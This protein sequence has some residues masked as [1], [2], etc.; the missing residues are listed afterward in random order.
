[1]NI[2]PVVPPGT[3]IGE[4]KQQQQLIQ[5]KNVIK[6]IIKEHLKGS[7]QKNISVYLIYRKYP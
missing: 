7:M 5:N 4:L 1:V 3:P 2:R 6:L